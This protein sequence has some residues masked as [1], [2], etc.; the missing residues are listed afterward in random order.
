MKIARMYQENELHEI[1]DEEERAAK[2]EQLRRH[3]GIGLTLGS[4]ESQ[5]MA[6]VIPNGI[7]HAVKDKLGVRAYERYMDDTMA[8][9]PSKEE[10]KHVGQT[11]QSEA[12]EVG[13]SMNAKKTAITKASKG[14]KFLQIYY[15]VTDTGHLVKNLA[16]A[17][18]VRMRRKLKA[19]A[20]MV[21]R[22]VMRLDDAFASFSAWF[23]N[24]FHADAYHTRKR[25]LSLYWRLF[26]GYRMKGVY[27]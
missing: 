26:H 16:R 23:G 24:S 25:M 9:G 27:A 12:S 5:T 6:L 10:L 13:L 18:I 15:K 7:D 4:Q 20:R 3:K 17:G 21:Q 14:M 11:I 22:G 8:A 1:A 19:F 2:A